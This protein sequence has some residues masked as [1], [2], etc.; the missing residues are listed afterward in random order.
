MPTTV[1][2]SVLVT[3]G[4]AVAMPAPAVGQRLVVGERVIGEPA[5]TARTEQ[6]LFSDACLRVLIGTGATAI[7][8]GTVA[9]RLCPAVRAGS[10]ALPVKRTLESLCSLAW[11]EDLA[12]AG[13]GD[14]HPPGDC[15]NLNVLQIQLPRLVVVE[16]SFVDPSQSSPFTGHSLGG[17]GPAPAKSR[18]ASFCPHSEQT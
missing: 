16:P 6:V 13:I 12:D 15:S 10:T 14:P 2:A 11:E 9:C 8:V 7:L 4:C 5:L 3:A 18:I 1:V 17:I